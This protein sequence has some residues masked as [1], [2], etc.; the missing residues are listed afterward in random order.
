MIWIRRIGHLNKNRL[1]LVALFAIFCSFFFSSLFT[2][3][4]S[5]VSTQFSPGFNHWSTYYSN[6]AYSTQPTYSRTGNYYG[7]HT[8]PAD[9]MDSAGGITTNNG[10]RLGN[11]TALSRTVITSNPFDC[12]VTNYDLCD[13]LVGHIE[14]N[15]VV[16]SLG[17]NNR[18]WEFKDLDK[19]KIGSV[20][21]FDIVQQSVSYVVTP[22]ST[23]IQNLPYATYY[24]SCDTLTLYF[25]F[26]VKPQNTNYRTSGLPLWF[27]IPDLTWWIRGKQNAYQIG[28]YAEKYVNNFWWYD[29]GE[30]DISALQNIANVVGTGNDIAGEQLTQENQDRQDLQTVSDDSEADGNNATRNAENATM[31]LI[32][33][34][35]SI[36]GIVM[37][38]R[39][40]DCR[41]GPI[42]LYN[43]MDLGTMDFCTVNLPSPIWAIG[44]LLTVGLILLLA[45]SV[46][47]CA[48]TLYKD[49]FGK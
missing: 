26:I 49:L 11:S 48:I 31:P 32:G 14:F 39:Q 27:D 13:Y 20:D 24:V 25:D 10:A 28:V 33:A 45:W 30:I 35:T 34:I 22:W 42:N 23:T 21:N 15:L 41:I 18:P 6:N 3:S 8:T 16:Y 38:P 2:L 17:Q 46:L 29:S 12:Y 40:T 43:Q 47:H 19:I 4:A 44:S 36:Y 5:A 37:N 9:T 1:I 7:L